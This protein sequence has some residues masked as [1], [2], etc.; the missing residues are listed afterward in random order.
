M[1]KDFRKN[2]AD[3]VLFPDVDSAGAFMQQAVELVGDG[4]MNT[5]NQEPGNGFWGG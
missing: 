4:V 2:G 1:A 3:I 5:V